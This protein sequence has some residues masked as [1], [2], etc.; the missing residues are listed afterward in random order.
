M[1]SEQSQIGVLLHFLYT[2]TSSFPFAFSSP[3][4]TIPDEPELRCGGLSMNKI[5]EYLVLE[6]RSQ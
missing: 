1:L 2:D 5:V 4:V 3:R 6:S